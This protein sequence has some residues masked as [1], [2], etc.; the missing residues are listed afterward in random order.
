[1]AQRGRII[2]TA[3]GAEAVSFY[4][5][6]RRRIAILPTHALADIKAPVEV[7]VNKDEAKPF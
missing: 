4:S 6:E 7:L 2:S 3:L 5:E 1:L